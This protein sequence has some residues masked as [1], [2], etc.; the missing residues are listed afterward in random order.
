[1][2]SA[3]AVLL[4]SQTPRYRTVPPGAV[5]SW[6]PE[7]V[8]LAASVG[9]HLD[10]GQAA[11]IHDGLS[12]KADGTWLASEVADDEPRQ[13]GKGA[14]LEARALAGLYLLKE[15]LIIWTAHEFKTAHEGFLRVRHYV[16]NFD[17]LR[18]R[19]RA[20]RSSTHA[21]EI[22]L[23]S[24][25]RRLAFLAR[26]GGS[27]RGFA[28][29]APL[30]LDEAFA[31]TA[32][33]MAAL[34]F[35]MSAHPNPQVWYMSSAPLVDSDVLRG[36]CTR[37]RLGSTGLVYYEWSASGEKRDLEKLVTDNKALSDEAADT[38]AGRQ[39][40]DRLFEKVAEANRAFRSRI[41]ES[42]ILRELKATG[43]EQF[44]RERLGVW[45]ELE[46]GAAI[47]STSW[48]NLG[49]PHSRRDG[50]VAL[51]VDIS[52][53]R[54]WAAIGLYGH[55]ED[56][57]GHLQLVEYHAG[58]N[59]IIP[60]LIEWRAA[61]DPVAVG[62]ARGTY[63]SLKKD[64]T[65]A[66]FIRPEDRP[67]TKDKDNPHPPQRGD[68]AVM[69]GTDMAAACGQIID[70]VRQRSTRHV[71]VQQVTDAV[72]GAKTRVTGDTVAWSRTAKDIDITGLVVFTEARWSYYARVDA[73][74]VEDYD[75]TEDIW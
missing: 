22:E 69:T 72:A 55:R 43:A 12:E 39:L 35:A 71:P 30:F 50:D 20:I 63:A 45:S 2:N 25:T 44:M 57:L 54:D 34:I 36:I 58:T 16:D 5:S 28:G 21:V 73:I 42:S 31:L 61:I 53:E 14:I 37:G 70:A 24:P 74:Q 68:L 40:R 75:P 27:G 62:M 33:Q 64:L 66:G 18:K 4:G 17:H 13:N 46:S 1:M 26:S 7:S 41:L 23:F 59:W 10:D 15:P 49:D 38:D 3:G 60:K 9:L 52:L 8:D 32:E 67:P 29:V 56:G 51:A 19:V 65:A 48:A 11:V 47:D 6:G